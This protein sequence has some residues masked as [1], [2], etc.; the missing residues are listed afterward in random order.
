VGAFNT[1]LYIGQDF[2]KGRGGLRNYST[3]LHEGLEVVT[4]R[5]LA[6]LTEDLDGLGL[7]TSCKTDL[8]RGFGL[9]PET[10]SCSFIGGVGV[11]LWAVTHQKAAVF[12]DIL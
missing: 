3:Y 12:L 4:R 2:V 11:Q 5:Y 10:G 8:V 7:W 9:S 6:V 1:Y